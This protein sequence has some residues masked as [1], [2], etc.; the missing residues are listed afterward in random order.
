MDFSLVITN[1][2]KAAFVD[3]AVRSC[4]NQFLLRKK[5]E[6]LVVDDCSTDDSRTIL[7]EFERSISI[8]ELDENRGVAHASNV[9]L[10]KSHAPYWMRVDADDYLSAEACFHMGAVLD[11]NPHYD[12]VY[13]DHIRID[14]RGLKQAY[15]RLDSE[16]KLFE[17]GAGILFRKERLV[18]VG[19]YDE[20]LRNAE[21]YDLLLRLRERGC[22]GFYLPVPL[23]RYYIH[24]DNMTLS[25]ERAMYWEK[26]NEK[27]G[28]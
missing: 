16:R 13:C 12:F 28:I 19:A 26:V 22:K 4:L 17:H 21:D 23:Y 6:V 27:H 5:V 24:G 14:L 20:T 11:N 1:Y 15:V 9:G 7:K 3:R 25:N 10:T 2:N 8:I 18:E